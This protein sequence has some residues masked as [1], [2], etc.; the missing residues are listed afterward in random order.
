[1]EF[2]DADEFNSVNGNQFIADL[3]PKSPVYVALL[4]EAAQ[5]V[6]G[7]PHDRGVP[8]MK[9]LDRRGLPLR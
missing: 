6:I 7:R 8:A 2:R 4:S 9:M 1:M 3:M 5:A